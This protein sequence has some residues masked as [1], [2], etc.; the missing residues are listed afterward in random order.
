VE[1]C[2]L[3]MMTDWLAKNRIT[4]ESHSELIATSGLKKQNISNFLKIG[5]NKSYLIKLAR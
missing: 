4:P 2:Q 5:L 1:V 3:L